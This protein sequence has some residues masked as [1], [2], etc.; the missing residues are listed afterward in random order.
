M[1]K[2]TIKGMMCGHCVETIEKKL[3]STEGVEDV[4]VSLEE[5]TAFISG[6]VEND[7]IKSV[8]EGEGYQV[9]SVENIEE[10]PKDKKEKNKDKN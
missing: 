4:K 10:Y 6:E 8:I 2:I 5:K 7:L 9:I 3:K 1:K